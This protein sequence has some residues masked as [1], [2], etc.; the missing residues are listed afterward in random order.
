VRL[1][2]LGERPD[3]LPALRRLTA[4]VWPPTMAYINHDAVC[5][6]HWPALAHDFADFQL[7]LCDGRGRA[8]AGGYT[9]PFVWDGRPATLP[10]GVRGVL[11]R[12]VRDHRR[13]RRPTALSALCSAW[14]RGP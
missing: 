1:V 14:R 8:V 6:H 7:L 13:G 10:S 11:A 12:G 3:L 4:S 9:I 2:T 5:D